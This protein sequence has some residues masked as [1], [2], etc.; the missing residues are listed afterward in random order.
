LTDAQREAEE[1]KVRARRDAEDERNALLG[2]VR[3]QVATLA[4][5]AAERVIAQSLDGKKAQAIVADFFSK[6]QAANNVKNL[7]AEV[8]VTSALPL[9]DGEKS[10]IASE[11]GAKNLSYKVDPSILG[12]LVFRAGE[13]VVDASVRAN[14]QSLATQVH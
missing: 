10:K 8:E 14:L 1:I 6:P 12:G 2:E 5:A 3:S 9:T 13:T 7:G 11:T 4:I